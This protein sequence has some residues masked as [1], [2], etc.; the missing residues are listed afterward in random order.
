MGMRCEETRWVISRSSFTDPHH[1]G[2]A[3][4]TTPRGG[5]DQQQ[6]WAMPQTPIWQ[7]DQ[8]WP[9]QRKPSRSTSRKEKAR[10][11]K[12]EKALWEG[13]GTPFATTTTSPFAGAT[14]YSTTMPPAPWPPKEP[15]PGKET[16]TS[17]SSSAPNAEVVEAIRASYPDAKDMPPKMKEMVAKYDMM[18][19]K[20]VAKD[21]EQTWTTLEQR[22]GNLKALRVAKQN[23]RIAWL[24]SLQETMTTWEGHVKAYSA[25]QEEFSRMI[26]TAT[27]EIET[28]KLSLDSLSRQAGEGLPNTEDANHEEAEK[29]SEEKEKEARKKLMSVMKTCTAMA[30]SPQQVDSSGSEKG[31]DKVEEIDDGGDG[32]RKRGRAVTST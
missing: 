15:M 4:P 24:K 19:R 8:W 3:K 32:P 11:K 7:G 23:H 20:M 26:A 18:N 12:E 5:K 17:S 16:A 2:P 9:K 29:A 6:V 13:G 31:E 1:P 27:T 22:Q 28:T 21:M 10:K 30:S 25:Q 14:S